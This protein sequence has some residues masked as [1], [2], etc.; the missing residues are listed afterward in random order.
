MTDILVQA[1]QVQREAA[2]EKQ[3]W[4]R[5]SFIQDMIQEIVRLRDLRALGAE[6]KAGPLRVVREKA[7]ERQ[8]EDKP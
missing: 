4:I 2:N 1:Q 8:E 3:V 6:A 5:L 7:A